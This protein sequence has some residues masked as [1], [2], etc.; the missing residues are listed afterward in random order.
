MFG[1]ILILYL[2]TF[3][4]AIQTSRNEL[5]K[6]E[7]SANETIF[8]YLGEAMP[9]VGWHVFEK[10]KHHPMGRRFFPELY[11]EENIEEQYISQADGFDYWSKETGV[12]IQYFTTLWGDCYIEFGYCAIFYIMIIAFLWYKLVCKK[13]E[14]I[15]YLPLIFYYYH[16]FVIYGVFNHGFSGSRTHYMFILLIIICYFIYKLTIKEKRARAN[17]SYC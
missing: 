3:V 11:L 6:D 17:Y 7:T 8:L 12:R 2:I 14:K 1:A 13:Y 10:V 16:M 9:N 5:R 4:V 15:Y